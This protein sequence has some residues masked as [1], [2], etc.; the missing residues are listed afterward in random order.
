MDIG[1]CGTCQVGWHENVTGNYQE[2]YNKIGD[3]NGEEFNIN[4]GWI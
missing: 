1:S 4:L 2:N 3:Q